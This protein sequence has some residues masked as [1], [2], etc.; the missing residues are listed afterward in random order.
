MNMGSSWS[1]C[2]C[3]FPADPSSP[4]QCLKAQAEQKKFLEEKSQ[5]EEEVLMG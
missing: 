3:S 2:R 5:F 4:A 1:I